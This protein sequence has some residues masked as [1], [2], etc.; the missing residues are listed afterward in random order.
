MNRIYKVIWSRTKQAYVVVSEL[1]KR[2]AKSSSPHSGVKSV[3]GTL[4]VGGL[5]FSLGGTAHAV[6]EVQL[7][8]NAS[9]SGQAAIAIGYKSNAPALNT[10]AIGVRALT[11]HRNSI[12][13][14][15]DAQTLGSND[16]VSVGD[17]PSLGD[18]YF[19]GQDAVAIG[20]ASKV[21]GA[22]A[23]GIGNQAKA[24]GLGST[25]I[26][27]LSSAGG[28]WS[29]ALGRFANAAGNSSVAMG[30]YSSASGQSTT[31][32][33]LYTEAVADYS[34]AFGRRA[35]TEGKYSQAMG[36]FALTQ[37]DESVALGSYAVA[38]RDAGSAGYDIST[39]AA[40]PNTG[41]AWK[42]TTAAVSIGSNI[43]NRELRDHYN[44][45]NELMGTRGVVTRQLIG[46]AAGTEDTDAVNVAQLKAIRTKYA[47]DNGQG[48]NTNNVL[49]K[50]PSETLNIL[51]G[52]SDSTN[53]NI[54]VTSDSNA[55]N[56]K[57]AANVK[58]LT[59]VQAVSSTGATT[60]TTGDSIVSKLNE[61]NITTIT[62]GTVT[63]ISTPTRTNRI[64]RL[65]LAATPD[66]NTDNTQYP[67]TNQISTVAQ[68]GNSYRVTGYTQ[69]A[70]QGEISKTS[71]SGNSTGLDQ[72]YVTSQ[73]VIVGYENG[74]SANSIWSTNNDTS[75]NGYS[76]SSLTTKGLKVQGKSNVDQNGSEISDTSNYPY[77]NTAYSEEGVNVN[78]GDV[79]LQRRGLTVGDGDDTTTDGQTTVYRSGVNVIG[80]SA[81]YDAAT[82]QTLDESNK[83]ATV[84]ANGL[85]VNGDTTKGDNAAVSTV[86]AQGLNVNDPESSQKS[87]VTAGNVGL[88]NG[89]LSS[90]LNT[91]NLTIGQQNGSGGVNLGSQTLT[92]TA[93]KAGTS[94]SENG[95]YL[96]GLSNKQWNVEDPTY[97]SGRAATEDQLKALT[98][99]T[100]SSITTTA[101]GADA[102]TITKEQPKA[103]FTSGKNI[104]L[105]PST[106]GIKVATKDDVEFN[107]V[108]V[109]DKVTINNTGIDAGNT[110]IKNVTSGGTTDSNA[111]TIGDVKNARTIVAAGQNTFVKENT[112][113]GSL[114]TT[115]TV[116]AKN[117]TV[118]SADTDKVIVTPGEMDDTTK[119]TDYKVDLSQ[120]AKDAINQVSTNTT[121]IETN[122]NSITKL[123]DGFNIADTKD[124]NTQ[125]KLGEETRPTITFKG[126]GLADTTVSGND[127]TVSVDKQ[128]VAEEINN[129]GDATKITNIGGTFGLTGQDNQNATADINSNVK[130]QG[131]NTNISTS[132]KD[133]ALEIALNKDLNLGE[134]GS[135]TTGATTINNN[136]VTVGGTIVTST[137]IT[138]P[139]ATIG[140]VVKIDS[141]GIDAGNTKITRVEAGSDSTDAVNVSQ[142]EEV[143]NSAYKG[144]KVTDGKVDA[145]TVASGKQV[146]FDGKTVTENDKE[147]GV[148]SKM[149]PADGNATITYG[150]TQDT[151]DAL[152][153][154]D[155][156]GITYTSDKGST[157]A[158]KLGETL[159]IK[160]SDNIKTAASGN[161][162]TIDLGDE[163]SVGKDGV[164]GVDGKIGVNGKDG[165][166]V[167]LNGK[168]GSIGMNGADGKVTT[169]ST[170]TTGAPGV[171][172]QDGITRIEYRDPNGKDHTVATLDDGM[173]YGGD[174][175]NVISKK[176][177]TQVN[178][179]G[180]ISDT[181]K[182]TDVDNIG[183]VSDGSDTLKVR[184]AKNLNLGNDGSVTTGKTKVDN[185]GV[186]ITGSAADSTKNVSLTNSGLNNGGN[187]IT[188]VGRGEAGTD[189]VNVDQLNEVKQVAQQHTTVKD[190]GKNIKVTGGTNADGGKEYTVALKPKVDLGQ[191]G[192]LTV[193]QTK[194]DNNGVTVGDT[195]VTKDGLKIKDGPS[196]TK[197]GI[198]AGSK[199]ITNVESGLNGQNL[200]DASGETLKN[201]AN[202]GDLQEMNTNINNT[203][204]QKTAA[205]KTEVKAG[206]N[207]TV[208]PVETAQDGHTIY[209][210]NAKD[211][212]TNV[213]ASATNDS[214]YFKVETTTE[215]AGTNNPVNNTSVG[216]TNEAVQILDSVDKGITYSANEGSTDGIKLGETLSVKGDGENVITK[217]SGK[218]LTINLGKNINLGD[219]S[220]IT[221]STVNT[222]IVKVTG[223]G[224]NGQTNTVTVDGGTGTVS[225][226]TNQTIDSKDFA[227]GSGRAATEEQLGDMG[228]R[229]INNVNGALNDMNTRVNRVG[230]S[231][232]ALAALHPQDFDP[233]DKLD[234]A[235]GFGN[236]KSTNAVAIGAFY[237]PTENV[238]FSVG[239]SFSGGEKMVNAGVTWKFK[240]KNSVSRS[241]VAVAKDVL[242]LKQQVEA[243][244][245]ELMAYKQA[246]P[247]GAAVKNLNVNFPDV[248]KD[249]WAYTYVKSLADR[250]YL[251]GYPDG[252]FKGDRSMT[253]YE[254]AA[255]IYRA[256]QN[257]APLDGKMVQSMK[258][259]RPEIAEVQ[260]ADH[261]R[262]DRIK[263]KD[264]DRHK[265]ERVRVN[266][267]D[268]DTVK[269]DVYGNHIKV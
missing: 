42:A 211:T 123:Q 152:K 210:V 2:A 141:T 44:G 151:T 33:G 69:A 133:N 41:E 175:G 83:T 20:S 246:Q 45:E 147:Y 255:I 18:G 74:D 21:S 245:K 129:G 215:G 171:D 138:T 96:T 225:G 36:S 257:G 208:N 28:D 40:T 227:D 236:Y 110:V 120:S 58:N 176:L 14:G 198:D 161:T 142:L 231:A 22:Y 213:T 62:P 81:V 124:H 80:G 197:D 43:K 240:Q 76:K 170:T 235:A 219:N 64:N 5:L 181:T 145:Q 4:M 182:L 154:V 47:G 166:A 61:G 32:L 163:L 220:S 203:I 192:S 164:D 111:A 115:Y 15:I 212:V 261:F 201:A 34:D 180:G 12:A 102:Q 194:V 126:E 78:S 105:T 178:V 19:P 75:G 259:F 99:K 79:L 56:V 117:T 249:H 11:E 6:W 187:K 93:N 251:I 217:G 26:G 119:T 57:L 54:S 125:I 127:V 264:N 72:T 150:L 169:I 121:N 256:L 63:T 209:T 60:T 101:D 37:K 128:K 91:T 24:D 10:I 66:S 239:G 82:G 186:T 223:T 16:W 116:D 265:I 218:D 241:R 108:K 53:N 132:V 207:V 8:D 112:P 94:S 100:L 59:S 113:D 51:G 230:A 221:T 70:G 97:V 253:R 87:V 31:A 23:T 89:S 55:L 130:V 160:G 174:T 29:F 260:E 247:A 226:L 49:S 162:V 243:L 189:A 3:A 71:Y 50:K 107:Q 98:D 135:V 156:S 263:G 202:I 68:Q 168:D 104:K 173:K 109:G 267:E 222:Q 262:V 30:D 228:G 136:G 177:N 134:D 139:S 95:N 88:T 118:S 179:K 103:N 149:T 195:S 148:Q 193:G 7:A 48:S 254:Y 90:N 159:N 92:T 146:T 188:N 13:I 237:R 244:T 238:M 204:D 233:D 1:A 27:M 190:D 114:Q 155:N 137:G 234:F 269:R 158:V 172:G 85:T 35:R 77:V 25:A 258:E 52:A 131:S 200:A 184:L 165:S 17:D 67:I 191:D 39:D 185:S 206:D 46:V 214:K 268:T 266:D 38:N 183:V 144:W 106:N 205:A 65:M 229:I 73:G 143:K 216:L 9:A 167:V 140:G 224:S 252:E 196:V 199:Q 153:K 250:G 86:T 248:P 84:Q 242:A 232:A 157:N 122:K